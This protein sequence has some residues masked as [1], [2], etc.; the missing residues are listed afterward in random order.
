MA[1]VRG[2]GRAER[3]LA[4]N[5]ESKRRPGRRPRA[6]A[7]YPLNLEAAGG[8]AARPESAVLGGRLYWLGESYD[9]VE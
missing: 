4:S 1:A 8:A 7:R 2:H 6:R 9:T 5:R 3:L